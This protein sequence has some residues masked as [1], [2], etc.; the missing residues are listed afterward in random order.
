MIVDVD[1]SDLVIAAPGAGDGYWAG[2]PSAVF[3][4]DRYYLAYRLRRP[5]DAGRGY[6]NVVASSV[7]GVHFDTLAVV[8]KSDIGTASLE[9][10]ALVRRSDGGWRLFVSLSTEG[11]KHWRVDALDADAPES[12]ANGRRFP[13]WPGDHDTA[14]KD[15]VIRVDPTGWHA[16]LCCHPLDVP[17]AEDRMTTR[18]ARSPDGVNWAWGQTVLAPNADGWDRRGRRLTSVLARADGSVLASYDGRADS[19]ENFYERT[20][21]AISAGISEAFQPVPGEISQSPHGRATLRYL[22]MLPMPNGSVRLYFEAANASG[23]NEIRT[24]LCDPDEV[25]G[26]TRRL[27]D[28]AGPVRG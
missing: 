22:S 17:G 19:A 25:A 5:V 2:G 16:W 9:R 8:D 26:W 11:S 13:V 15:P 23:S 20:G 10:P 27:N 6:A 28:S 3:S 18:Y 24:Q 1:R 7:D 21:L 4:D 14:V 12:L